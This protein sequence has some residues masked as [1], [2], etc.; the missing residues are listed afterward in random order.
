M[1]KRLLALFLM[2]AA[3]LSALAANLDV[4]PIPD[5]PL[6][7]VPRTPAAENVPTESAWKFSLGGGASYAPRY[8]G[9]ANDRMRFMP[10][11]EASYKDGKAFISLLRGMGY[12]FS[13]ERD[14]QYGVRL[15]P[16]Y[17]RWQSDD[18][19]LNGTGD[20]RFIPEAGLFF[21]RRFA[22]WYVSSGISTGS[23]GVHAELGA[24]INFPLST[25]D[26]LRLG[27]NLNWGDGRFNQTYFGVTPEQAAASGYVLTTYN[28]GAGIKD[29][30]LTA[31][32][33]HN[34]SREWFSNGGVSYKWLTGPALQ[35]PLVQR[36]GMESVN[37]LVGYRF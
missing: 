30:A 14:T 22:P 28:A 2:T 25:A 35:S 10:L 8:E 24:G 15:A 16:G 11:L 13:D 5:L 26:R 21:N 7:N 29:Y 27:T 36:R 19:R 37:F 34:Y 33:L 1:T 31:N 3:P 12:N 17:G 9:A 6:N 4:E 20:I 23:H 32:W 18:P